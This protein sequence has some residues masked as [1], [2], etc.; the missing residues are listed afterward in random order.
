[1]NEHALSQLLLEVVR[2]SPDR[3]ERDERTTMPT[4]SCPPLPRFRSAL[5][6][7][8]W[9]EGE[10]RHRA[11][12][13]YCRQTEAQARRQLWHPSLLHLF[14][15]ARGLVKT[16]VDAG[17][18]LDKDG[19]RRCQRLVTLLQADRLLARLAGRVRQGIPDAAT[20]LGRMLAS[21]AVALLSPS[22]GQPLAFETAGHS[23]TLLRGDPPLLRL[24]QQGDV[25]TPRLLRV[26]VGD[27]GQTREHFAVPC[28]AKEPGFLRTAIPL[29]RLPTDR[30]TLAVYEVD[31]SVLG[32]DEVPQLGSAFAAAKLD[33]AAVPVWQA[34]A[35]HT[36]KL[37]G[38]DT[39]I[40]PMLEQL[41]RPDAGVR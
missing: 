1:M 19:C 21:G 39:A 17:Q 4:S 40:R 2:E 13:S 31:A 7:E 33:P 3:P 25:K 27:A 36:L 24:E 32:R 14:W 30:L 16:D 38:L 12:C 22:P 26:L 6:R 29:E 11:E 28:P 20:R 15:H 18:H 8:D 23:A 35:S 10:E 9:T 5:F 34:W 41:A 37:A